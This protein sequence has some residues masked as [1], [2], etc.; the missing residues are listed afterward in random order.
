[1]P[2]N[3]QAKDIFYLDFSKAFDRVPHER[4]LKKRY[5]YGIQGNVLGWIRNF[6]TD[7][8]QRVQIQGSFSKWKPVTSGIPQGSFL[9]PFLFILFI[10]N[11]SDVVKSFSSLFA[12]DTKIF[13]PANTGRER[14]ILQKDLN[15]LMK[16]SDEWQLNFNIE[17]CYA[18][19]QK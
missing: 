2:D 10:N 11:L 12:D 6:L 15:K 3:K 14:E 9:G 1:M 8:S 19:Q 5:A 18:S 17:K 16:W 13:G 7:R 4:L